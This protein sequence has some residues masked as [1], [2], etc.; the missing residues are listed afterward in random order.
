MCSIDGLK[1]IFIII[2]ENKGLN[3]KKNKQTNLNGMKRHLII[4]YKLMQRR[5]RKNKNIKHIQRCKDKKY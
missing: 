5:R 2:K 1:L 3:K 4:S